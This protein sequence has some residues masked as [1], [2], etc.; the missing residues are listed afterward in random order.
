MYKE[1]IH[2]GT[3]ETNSGIFEIEI[4]NNSENL[5]FEVDG[6]TFEGAT[7]DDFEIINHN[8][9]SEAELQRFS[10]NKVQCGNEYVYELCDCSITANFPIQIK[11]LE[12]HDVFEENLKSKVVIGESIGRGGVKYIETHLDLKIL[13]TNYSTINYDFEDGFLDLKKQIAPTYRFHNCFGCNFSDYSP[14]GKTLFADMHCYKNQKEAYLK[15]KD[16]FDFFR[17]KEEDR[18]VQETY[19]CDDFEPRGTNIGYRG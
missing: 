8:D 1:T 18:T 13:E 16:K 19:L 3:L 9:Y 14:Y 10:F 2:K 5:R 17:L 15:V 6:F 7:F 4:V 12:T 11:N